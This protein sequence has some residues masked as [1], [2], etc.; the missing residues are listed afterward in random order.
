MINPVPLPNHLR[1]I[2]HQTQGHKSRANA[3]Y[4][5]EFISWI[6]GLGFGMNSVY[7]E[8]QLRGEIM[9]ESDGGARCNVRDLEDDQEDGI[10]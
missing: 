7:G 1:P 3:E 4:V 2:V 9:A 5:T 6:E 8:P 10:C